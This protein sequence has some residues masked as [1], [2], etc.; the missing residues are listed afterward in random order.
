MVISWS[1][2]WNNGTYSCG[3]DGMTS[4]NAAWSAE[5]CGG[6]GAGYQGGNT[7][8]VTENAQRQCYSGAGGSSWGDEING[9]SYTT[10]DGGATEGGNGKAIITWYGT[11]YPT[12]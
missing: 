3:K 12:E 11:T 9:K 7:W 1:I 8:T 6:G 5:G 4:T 10:T 2:D